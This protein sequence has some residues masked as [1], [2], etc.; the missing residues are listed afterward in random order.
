MMHLFA[1]ALAVAV[2]QSPTPQQMTERLVDTLRTLNAAAPGAA[3]DAD[4]EAKL[5]PYFDFDALAAAPLAPH[6]KAFTAKQLRRA[7]VAFRVLLVRRTRESGQQLT[8]AV[9]VPRARPENNRCVVD[10]TVRGDDVDGDSQ[11]AFAWAA[12]PRGWRVV[13]LALDGASVVKEYENQFGRMLRKDGA[14]KLV[15]KLEERAK[16]AQRPGSHP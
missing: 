4:R 1:L 9:Q 12:G 7:Q 8:G 11:V 15:A 10:L 14:E 6:R 5:A 3:A 16:T 2:A 13:D